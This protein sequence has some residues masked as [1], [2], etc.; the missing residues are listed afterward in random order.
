MLGSNPKAVWF[1]LRGLGAWETSSEAD[2]SARSDV[3]YHYGWAN[4]RG[5]YKDRRVRTGRSFLFVLISSLLF[6]FLISLVQVGADGTKTWVPC[7]QLATSQ[8]SARQHWRNERPVTRA[9]LRTADL[10]ANTFPT[11]I[12]RELVSGRFPL[13]GSSP[14]LERTKIVT[15]GCAP[16]HIILVEKLTV[17]RVP[18]KIV[19]QASR[20]R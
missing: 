3:V 7:R 13:F 20:E 17:C 19:R 18:K 4:S 15:R 8:I 6:K 10:S 11:Q 9:N 14:P 1:L 16:K 5:D 12:F 2:L